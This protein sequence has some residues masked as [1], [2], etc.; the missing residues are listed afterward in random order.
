MKFLKFRNIF[1]VC[2]ILSCVSYVL[3]K[4]FWRGEILSANVV[5]NR[6]GTETLNIDKFRDGDEKV[7]AKMAYSLLQ[8]QKEFYGVFV[9]DI[10]NR[11]GAP[12]GFYFSDTF[13]AYMIQR[14][15]SEGSWQIVFLLNKERKVTE[16]IVHK[17]CCDK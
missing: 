15:E 8:K 5:A 6:W 12:D 11:F 14:S 1:V 16:V 13:P 17:N 10:R 4:H 2:V 3:A 9:T 7:R